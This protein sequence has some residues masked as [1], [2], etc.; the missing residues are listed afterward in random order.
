MYYDTWKVLQEAVWNMWQML[1]PSSVLGR[2]TKL[3]KPRG[4]HAGLLKSA[5]EGL[6]MCFTREEVAA[7]VEGN[8]RVLEL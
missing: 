6:G 1:L 4:V 7:V 3:G 8:P 2:Y 5:C